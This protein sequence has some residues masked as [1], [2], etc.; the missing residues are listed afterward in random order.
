MSESAAWER[1]GGRHRGP[2]SGF[3]IHLLAVLVYAAVALGAG[4]GLRDPWPP[5]E[6]RFALIAREMVETGQWLFPH[7]AGHLYADKP[8]VFFWVVAALYALTGSLRLAIFAPALLAGLAAVW[9]VGDLAR[10]LWSPTAGVH[11]AAALALAVQFAVEGRSG[12][13]D[14]LLFG[15]TTLSLYGLL[16]HL[17]L[18]P[19][20]GWWVLGWVAAGLGVITKGVGFLPLLVVPLASVVGRR[21][22]VGSWRRAWLGPAVMLAVIAAW[23]VPMAVAATASGDPALA[24]YRDEILLRQT[25]TRYVDSWGHLKPP[26]YFVV[27]VIPVFWLPLTLLLP[28]L[29][30]RFRDAWQ[31]REPRVLLPL[32]WT[33]VVVLFFSASPGKRGVYV[34]PALPGLVLASAPWLADLRQRRAVQR[35]G[36][37]ALAVVAGVLVAVAAWTAWRP[38]D[39]V[40]RAQ[41]ALGWPAW[42]VLMSAAGL[43]ALAA[44][45]GRGRRVYASWAGAFL[46]LWVGLGL[47]V[48]PRLDGE[49]SGANLMAKVRET[50]PPGGEVGLVGWKEQFVLQAGIPVATFGYR[51][52]DR[53]QELADGLQWAAVSPRR[54]VL[55]AEDYPGLVLQQESGAKFLGVYHRQRWWLVSAED[56]AA[57]P[58]A[59]QWMAAPS[60]PSRRRE[61]GLEPRGE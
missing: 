9:L 15:F 29:V 17:L 4:L 45:L 40:V 39:E 43:F 37:V 8:P 46:V 48:F 13:I 60:P 26:W 23:L 25:V 27:N 11:A 56:V 1:G 14:G 22:T 16:R 47:A 36:R 18:G 52:R 28:W 12:Q 33:V 7:V 34:L 53:E 42:L 31:A 57:A 19:A 50:L 6:P 41:E 20:W 59:S 21:G 51:R 5:D 32:A 24:A 35:L 54:R 44:L 61:S 49:R 3:R 58:A 55:V 10:R 30:P 2:A 38:V